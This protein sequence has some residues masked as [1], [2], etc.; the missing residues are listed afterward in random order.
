MPRKPDADRIAMI[1]A[2]AADMGDMAA[3]AKYGISRRTLVNYRGRA[4]GDAQVAQ[5]CAAVKSEL[6]ATWIERAKQTRLK[7]LE[8]VEALAGTSDDLHAVTGAYKIV[9]DG[10]IAETVVSEDDDGRRAESGSVM[11]G[12]RRPIAQVEGAASRLEH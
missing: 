7:L 6:V 4:T 9:N 11:E 8:R 5:K 12:A 3:C 1:L 2:D 10:I